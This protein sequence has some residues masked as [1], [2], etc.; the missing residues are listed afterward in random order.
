MVRVSIIV[1]F[2]RF[3]DHAILAPLAKHLESEGVSFLQFSFRWFHLLFLRVLPVNS[4]IRM[5]DTYMVSS[6]RH[7]QI[8]ACFQADCHTSVRRIRRIRQFSYICVPGFSPAMER[9]AAVNGLPSY[10]V[11]PAGARRPR[12]VVRVKHRAFVE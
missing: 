11:V 2:A 5:W 10:Y 12:S 8:H 4:V 9:K 1:V 3:A 7:N 6:L